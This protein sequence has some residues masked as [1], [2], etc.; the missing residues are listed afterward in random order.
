M[1]RSA[2]RRGMADTREA[3]SAEAPLPVDIDW[4]LARERLRDSCHKLVGLMRSTTDPTR[5]AVG[6]WTVGDLSAHLVQVFSNFSLMARGGESPMPD[7][8]RIAEEHDAYL[9]AHPER[10]PHVLAD[11]VERAAEEVMSAAENMSPNDS[12]TWHG[13]IRVPA[14]VL[15]ALIVDE[16]IVHGWDI[17]HAE[18]R[19]WPIAPLDAILSVKG[20]VSVAP[21]FLTQE[22]REAR[23]SIGVRLRGDGRITF[24]FTGGEAR[25]SSYDEGP[26]DC[27]ISAA[28]IEFLLVGAGRIGMFGPIAKGKMVAYG[29][30]PWLGLKF[31]KYF[32]N[33]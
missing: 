14:A 22:G 12:V 16:A 2:Y 27:R 13:G 25:V 19:D 31:P 7:Q 17:A 26:V 32:T 1:A 15:L 33:P 3:V 18:Q 9:R 30:K 5:V 6:Y 21:N 24:R 11:G 20:L 10:D 8:R 28:P 4:A 29:K 23:A